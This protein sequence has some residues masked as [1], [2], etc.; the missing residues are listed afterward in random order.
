MSE[1]KWEKCA[2]CFLSQGGVTIRKGKYHL[3]DM[4]IKVRFGLSRKHVTFSLIPQS[5]GYSYNGGFFGG[6]KRVL[7]IVGKNR[8]A[9]RKIVELKTP[10]KE[11]D[12]EELQLMLRIVGEDKWFKAMAG[13]NLTMW[14]EIFRLMAG[15]A[16]GTLVI[17]VL[18]IVFQV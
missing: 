8:V 7:F 6:G 12:F 9:M 4:L 5:H 18:K 17:E 11:K 15:Y 1:H 16:I 2:V 10:L 13:K 3:G 14:E